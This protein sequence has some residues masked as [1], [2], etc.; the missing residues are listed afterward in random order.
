MKRI[1]QIRKYMRDTRMPKE[2]RAMYGM[3]VDDLAAIVE[4]CK[5]NAHGAAV[6]AFAYGKA[7]GYRAGR[8]EAK[9]KGGHT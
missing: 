8:L 2:L 4:E 6:M 3:D 5:G 9:R 1:Q 7:K